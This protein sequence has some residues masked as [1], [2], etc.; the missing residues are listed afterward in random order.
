MSDDWLILHLKY[1]YWQMIR[2]GDKTHEY[3]EVKPYWESRI[4][5]QKKLTLVPGYFNDN[6]VDIDAVIKSIKKI[7]YHE[8]PEYVQWAFPDTEYTMFYDIEF[9]VIK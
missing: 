4:R 1:E 6:S 7:P 2:D 3:R 8:L 9:E 5:N